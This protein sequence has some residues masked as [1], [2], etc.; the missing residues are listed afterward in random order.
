MSNKYETKEAAEHE[1]LV[2]HHVAIKKLCPLRKSY[3]SSNCVCFHNGN[4]RAGKHY[5]GKELSE[6]VYFLTKA[7]CT[8]AM[9]Y[10]E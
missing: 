7:H 9:F 8:N 5:K 4:V 3:C 10:H 6:A 1:L 2:S